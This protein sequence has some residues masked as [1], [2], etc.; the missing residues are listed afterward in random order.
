MLVDRGLYHNRNVNALPKHNTTTPYN[1]LSSVFAPWGPL[2][3]ISFVES[4]SMLALLGSLLLFLTRA[5]L[6]IEEVI[7]SNEMIRTPMI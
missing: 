2:F 3:V 5:S 4:K 1:I 7:Q 6:F